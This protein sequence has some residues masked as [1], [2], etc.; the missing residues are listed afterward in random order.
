MRIECEQHRIR[1]SWTKQFSSFTRISCRRL[2]QRLRQIISNVNNKISRSC[3]RRPSN[4]KN[5]NS[6]FRKYKKSIAS[7]VIALTF[8]MKT[9]CWSSQSAQKCRRLIMQIKNWKSHSSN[10]GSSWMK[11]LISS[12]MATV[13]RLSYLRFRNSS[14][15][16][17]RRPKVLKWSQEIVFNHLNS[18]MPT[19]LSKSQLLTFS[20]TQNWMG[21]L[22]R[23]LKKREWKQQRF[24][25]RSYSSPKSVHSQTSSEKV[26]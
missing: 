26:S 15:R 11:W 4:A 13:K 8:C 6:K 1:S 5:Q 16:S 23:M 12:K 18:S 24:S 7:G 9:W 10:T 17:K 22:T 20:S 25:M 3:E 14:K 2:K 19:I 21:L